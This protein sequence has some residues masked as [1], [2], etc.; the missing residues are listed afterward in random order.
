M[1]SAKL[2]RTVDN[3]SEAVLTGSH[4]FADW[5]TVPEAVAYSLSKG[6]NRTPKTIR[7]W[8]A[9]AIQS[10]TEAAEI[11][12]QR[13]DTENGFRWLISRES[14]DVKIQQ[15]K[16]F[17]QRNA[18]VSNDENPS[19]PVRTGAHMLAQVPTGANMFEQ[20]PVNES[21]TEPIRTD[22]N[23]SEHLRTAA[24][25]DDRGYLSLVEKELERAHRQI[26][27]K[28]KQID[29]LLE[30]DRETNILIQG[31]QSGFSRLLQALPH[32]NRD[33]SNDH[34]PSA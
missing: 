5:L 32:P 20:V 34:R 10:P 28:D 8:A 19:E 24:H 6:L 3:P 18:L 30:R 2:Q 11:I 17:E 25:P 27:V 31:L 1:N 29:A 13:Q 4:V 23:T 21:V 7:K 9:R 22:E 26:E 14:L 15:E 12:V 33:S 16:D